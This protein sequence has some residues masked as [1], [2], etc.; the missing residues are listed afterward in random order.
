VIY[1]RHAKTDRSRD[2]ALQPV[3]SD[4][5]TQRLL[6][7]DGEQ[8][9][10]ELGQALQALNIPVDQ[11]YCSPYC[12]AKATAQRA[13]SKRTATAVE[14]LGRLARMPREKVAACTAKLKE[15]LS[16]QPAEGKNA[17]IVGHIENL[18][19]AGGPAIEEAGWAVFRP[20]HGDFR[21]V[22]SVTP[23]QWK[24]LAR[25]SRSRP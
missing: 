2:D 19:A 10:D 6:S 11:I 18:V 23:A 22:V 25:T 5:A 16:R 21:L 14:E 8:Q 7:P 4:C 24:A 3:L 12:R 17:F 20:E 9:A 13:F 15:L 1:L